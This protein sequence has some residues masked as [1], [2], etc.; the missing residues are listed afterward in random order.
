MIRLQTRPLPPPPLYVT[1]D[2]RSAVTWAYML[3]CALLNT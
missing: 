1:L 2:L 3:T